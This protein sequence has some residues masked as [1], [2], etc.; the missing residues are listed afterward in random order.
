[1]KVVKVVKAG[2]RGWRSEERGVK[3]IQYNEGNIEVFV[4]GVNTYCGDR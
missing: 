2:K 3:L 1:M 4:F